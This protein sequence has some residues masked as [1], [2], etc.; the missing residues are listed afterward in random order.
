MTTSGTG[1]DALHPAVQFQI[2]NHYQWPGLR[3]VQDLSVAPILRGDNVVILA[4]TAGGKTEASFFPLV[5]RALFEGWEGLSILYI[6]PIRALLNNQRDRLETFMGLLGRRAAT[7]HGDVSASDKKRLRD[8]PP[9]LLL[10]TP[11]SLEAMLISTKTKK[12]A[13]FGNLRAV[14]IDEVHAFAGDDRGWHLL[15]VLERLARYAD[16]DLQ[17][18][19]LSATVG[20]RTEIVDWLS[21]GSARPRA[22]VDPPRPA[23]AAV[24]DVQVDW[25]ASL[26]N[27]AKVI[28]SLHRGEK[29]LVFC[30]SRKQAEELTRELR[31]R[32]VTTHV[33]HS[34]LS[35]DERALT[36]RQFAE[37][38]EGVIVATS[39]L[40]LGIDIGDLDRVIQIDAPWSVASFL[41]RMGR[42]GRRA[43]T[44]PNQLFL[45]ITDSGLLRAASIVDA[46]LADEVE[47]AVAPPFPW[48]VFAQQVLALVL[49]RPGII[50]ADLVARTSAIREGGGL[51][52]ADVHACI[53]HL[54][55]ESYLFEDGARLGVGRTGEQKLGHRHFMELMSVF[56]SPPLFTVMQG[57]K[58]IG[59]VS[60]STFDA[61]EEVQQ[62]LLLAGRTWRVGTI[63]W[64]RSIA[65]VE[66]FDAPGRVKFVGSGPG[67]SR[68]LAEAH[69]RVL[70]G[71]QRGAK[72]WSERASRAMVDLVAP[73]DFVPEQGTV[74]WGEQDGG[75]G[76]GGVLKAELQV[77]T[78]AG[79]AVNR[80]LARALHSAG[81]D[82]PVVDGLRLR[83]KG[84]DRVGDALR[85][86]RAAWVDGGVPAVAVDAEDRLVRGLKFGRLLPGELAAAA[87]VA[88]G[89]DGAGAVE[90][91]GA[92]WA[93]VREADGR[94]G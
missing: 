42:T 13:L 17:R 25:V 11:E 85:E 18:I 38:T 81:F 91:A 33:T 53:D 8:E 55:T 74:V 67:M 65:Y 89:F 23:N 92:G 32:E 62:I 29:R 6:S 44:R 70:R 21:H 30:D 50:R 12:R 90:V 94:A 80:T 82:P 28:A 86:A 36:E 63:D 61:A 84:P 2:V 15:G 47:P 5:S 52:D 19:G 43:G 88:R 69:R 66:P 20:N 51:R 27:A 16:H 34:S 79:D 68:M 77:Y 87:V 78:F 64:R 75:L 31:A 9:E 14:V 83:V 35:A 4:P 72:T 54:I 40:E 45:T 1:F 48:H 73:F 59:Q 7:W 56:T 37:G 76:D 49:E 41:Q 46:W 39:A 60:A 57:P 26:G 24:P 58:A 10:T 22:T 71:S 93:W 3:P